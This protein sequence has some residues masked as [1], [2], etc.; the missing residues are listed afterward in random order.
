MVSYPDILFGC[1]FGA[2]AL[3][4]AAMTFPFLPKIRTVRK[5]APQ[6][7]R[8]RWSRLQQKGGDVARGTSRSKVVLVLN[9]RHT[10][11]GSLD[12]R[13]PGRQARLLRQLQQG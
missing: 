11:S 6:E 8:S 1:M 3:Y 4:A 12:D 13:R 10:P 2:F 5:P 7:P 9:D